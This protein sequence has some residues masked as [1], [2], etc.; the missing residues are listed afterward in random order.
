MSTLKHLGFWSTVLVV[1]ALAGPLFNTNQATQASL[2]SEKRAAE[3]ALGSERAG[4]IVRRA[5]AVHAVIFQQSGAQGAVDRVVS[6]SQA[7]PSEIG[8][9]EASGVVS[10]TLSSFWNGLSA[11]MRRMA[12]RVALVLDWSWLV[13]PFLMLAV[14]DGLCARSKKLAE[15]GHQ[16]TGAFALGWHSVIG[17]CA[18]PLLYVIGPLYLSPL[19]MPVWALV[20]WF[21]LGIAMTNTQPIFVR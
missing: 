12:W 18:L 6:G 11:S 4:R 10:A 3:D 2:R 20:V 8:V 19:F 5:E 14:I 17:L 1:G 7:R 16:T 13:V 21:P 15:G 9:H